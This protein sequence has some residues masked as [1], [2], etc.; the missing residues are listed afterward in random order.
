MSLLKIGELKIKPT[1]LNST[2]A[3]YYVFS[4]SLDTN[5]YDDITSNKNWMSI[6]RN[7]Y[8]YM[9]CRDQ[10]TTWTYVNSFSALTTDEKIIASTHFA[11]AKTD[12][13]S[14]L[15]DSEQQDAWGGLIQE[16]RKARQIRWDAAK[17]YISYALPMPNSIDL[18]KTT[19]DLTHDYV[20]YGVEQFSK[21]GVDGLFDYLGNTSSYSGG[22]GYSGKTYWNQTDQDAM[23]TI[24]IDGIY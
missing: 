14:V 24:L 4:G 17:A 23:L 5:I 18:G 12:R 10:V 13:D 19:T 15:T 9:F 7:G 8:D 1:K 22:T 6:G 2:G 3:P 21:D 11:V 20:V 16:T